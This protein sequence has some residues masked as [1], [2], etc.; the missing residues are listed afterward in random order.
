MALVATLSSAWG[1]ERLDDGGKT[2]WFT[3]ENQD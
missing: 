1:V 3:V 2:V